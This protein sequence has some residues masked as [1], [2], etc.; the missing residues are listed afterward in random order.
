MRGARQHQTE[1]ARALAHAHH[2]QRDRRGKTLRFQRI[3]KT[4]ALRN[5]MPRLRERC[6]T[7]RRHGCRH[8]IERSHDGNP[9]FKQH[10]Q[11]EIKPRDFQNVQPVRHRRQLGEQAPQLTG[12]LERAQPERHAEQ[13]GHATRQQPFGV[14]RNKTAPGNQPLRHHRQF[15]PAALI[16]GRE[17]RHDVAQQ[18]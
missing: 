6:P 15:A 14:I 2:A 17:L 3:G 13:G 1:L 9:A 12:A 8:H 7:R 11:R 4:A 16:H 5:L 10:A 18:K